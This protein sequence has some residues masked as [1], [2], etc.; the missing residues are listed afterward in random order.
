MHS[1][2]VSRKGGMN[3]TVVIVVVIVIA[4]LLF[5]LLWN[6]SVASVQSL[7]TCPDC[8]TCPAPTVVEKVVEVENDDEEETV[9]SKPA[10]VA[11]TYDPEVMQDGAGAQLQRLITAY[12]ISRHL[13]IGYVHTPI[14]RINYQGLKAVESGKN[15]EDIVHRWNS[16]FHIPSD[17]MPETVKDVVK[18]KAEWDELVSLSSPVEGQKEVEPTLVHAAYY[19]F[20]A[21]AHPE[22]FDSI[23]YP[24][25]GWQKTVR[26]RGEKI[27][28][29]VHV[30]KGE[31]LAMQKHRLL[32]NAYFVGVMQHL[33]RILG[34]R[35]EFHVHTEAP[36]TSVKISAQTEWLGGFMTEE[37][38]AQK[39]VVLRRE[40]YGLDDFASIPNT[41]LHINGDPIAAVQAMATTDILVLSHSSFSYVAGLINKPALVIYHPFWHAPAPSWLVVETPSDLEKHEVQIANLLRTDG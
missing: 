30:R 20:A 1:L 11:L 3:S 40:D 12:A 37:E 24:L 25:F 26:Q 6:R 13:D 27:R 31:L 2:L 35:A 22:V 39:G 21:D 29:D 19:H 17:K 33:Y 9:A 34:S 18:E 4:L 14:S 28:I 8:P 38:G 5:F 16:L 10:I 32:D 41:H 15:D 7:K 23:P 36:K